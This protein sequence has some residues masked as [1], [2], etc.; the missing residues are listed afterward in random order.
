MRGPLTKSGTISA[1]GVSAQAMIQLLAKVQ[2]NIGPRE[3]VV[4]S[5]LPRGLRFISPRGADPAFD[6]VVISPA[7][8]KALEELPKANA[9]YVFANEVPAGQAFMG[10][11]VFDMDAADA[12]KMGPRAAARALAM[13]LAAAEAAIE[14]LSE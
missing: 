13:R 7:D 4:S 2:H 14:R 1:A 8:I 11:P 5:V 3:I 12:G 9:A 10:L 6:Y